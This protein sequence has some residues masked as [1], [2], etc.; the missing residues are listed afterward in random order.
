MEVLEDKYSNVLTAMQFIKS[1]PD[2]WMLFLRLYFTLLKSRYELA[3]KDVKSL[4]QAG[5]IDTMTKVIA[6]QIFE[7]FKEYKMPILS[8]RIHI[9][10]VHIHF[11]VPYCLHAL[12]ER[13]YFAQK[14]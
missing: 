8:C 12:H 10:P 14:F 4:W 1:E 7:T 3:C 6:C 13:V 11:M 2:W 5:V 9:I